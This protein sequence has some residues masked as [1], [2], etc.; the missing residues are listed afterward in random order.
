M[1]WLQGP[2]KYGTPLLRRWDSDGSVH[3]VTLP[4]FGSDII[5]DSNDALLLSAAGVAYVSISYYNPSLGRN[6]TS[7]FAVRC[8]DGALLWS[9]DRHP[10]IDAMA[11]HT[12]PSPAPPALLALS[13]QSRQL[14]MY[15]ALTGTLAASTPLHDPASGRSCMA[16]SDDGSIAII[17]E[18]D[19][20]FGNNKIAAYRCVRIVPLQPAAVSPPHALTRVLY[21][22]LS[23]LL[24]AWSAQNASFIGEWPPPLAVAPEQWL[25]P[26]FDSVMRARAAISVSL[27]GIT[28]LAFNGTQLWRRR[29]Q[30]TPPFIDVAYVGDFAVSSFSSSGSGWCG[31]VFVLVANSD[32]AGYV[33]ALN[34]S[35]G[36]IAAFSLYM[37]VT[38]YV[39]PN[40]L[41]DADGV[42]VYVST[43]D[44][45]SGAYQ[46]ACLT[47]V[48]L[49][50]QPQLDGSFALVKLWLSPPYSEIEGEGFM[51]VG[52]FKG[53]LAFLNW[54]GLFVLGAAAERSLV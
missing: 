13:S 25:G 8:D 10:F 11:M 50:L 3:D 26:E 52:P 53:Q 2:D 43:M 24:F 22:S 30:Y 19:D 31:T 41:L 1:F 37:R 42:T 6:C 45:C 51:A 15:S 54:Y 36:L 32:R 16:V 21:S 46:N 9:I 12:P 47:L 23:P 29:W 39:G 18:R 38:Q 35:G 44:Q 40:L 20:T 4:A 33:L 5:Q 27:A 7:L 28:A 34:C 17:Q 49:Q 48:A 14:L